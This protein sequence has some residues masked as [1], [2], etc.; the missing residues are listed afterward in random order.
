[1]FRTLISSILLHYGTT[2]LYTR[3]VSQQMVSAARPHGAQVV[4]AEQ[5]LGRQL[6]GAEAHAAQL[7]VQSLQW[8]SSVF[9]PATP[10]PHSY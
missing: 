2:T 5:Q 6:G 10:S 1:M 8:H 9:L 7:Q 3:S 4:G